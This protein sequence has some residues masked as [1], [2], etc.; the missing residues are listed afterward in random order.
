MSVT[1]DVAA[2][3]SI[4]ACRAKIADARSSSGWTLRRRST[5]LRSFNTS[6]NDYVALSS[7]LRSASWSLLLRNSP[8]DRDEASNIHSIAG[9][10]HELD[11]LIQW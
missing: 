11:D 9:L 10:L 8:T 5:S 4:E 2:L 3:Q 7:R 1:I 6:S